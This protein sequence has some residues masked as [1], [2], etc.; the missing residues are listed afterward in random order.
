M[1]K[2][3]HKGAQGLMYKLIFQYKYLIYMPYEAH[4]YMLKKIAA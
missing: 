3:V 1:D 2:N 4:C